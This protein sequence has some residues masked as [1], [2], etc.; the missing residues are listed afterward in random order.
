M[1]QVLIID[2]SKATRSILA[3][4]ISS[5]GFDVFEAKDGKEALQLLGTMY[6]PVLALVDWYMPGMDGV[7]FIRTVRADERYK[8]LRLMMVT[9]AVNAEHIQLAL[10]AGADEYVMKPFTPEII[11]EKLVLMGVLTN[12]FG[13]G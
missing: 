12:D 5:L 1:A 7:E 4:S 6:A 9:T 11:R 3:E 13:H 2:D 10:D 8:N